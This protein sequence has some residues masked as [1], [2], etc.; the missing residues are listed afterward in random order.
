MGDWSE[1]M[2]DNINRKK[3]KAVVCA[4]KFNLKFMVNFEIL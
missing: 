2:T 3:L 4:G 1:E